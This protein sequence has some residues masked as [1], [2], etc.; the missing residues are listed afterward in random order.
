MKKRNGS[1][2][3]FMLLEGLCGLLSMTVVLTIL[4][5]Q[6]I[7][8]RQQ[9]LVAEEKLLV[10]RLLKEETQRY[11]LGE[12]RQGTQTNLGE[13]YTVIYT[14]QGLAI[15]MGDHRVQFSQIE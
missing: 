2:S 5:P 12:N 4:Y 7:F 6:F 14:S 11:R 3:S 15:E 13:T 8:F 9:V 10:E 1:L